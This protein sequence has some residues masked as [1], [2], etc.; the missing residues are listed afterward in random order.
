MQHPRAATIQR[1]PCAQRRHL[2]VSVPKSTA[3]ERRMM[4]ESHEARAAG[5]AVLRAALSTSLFTAR[6]CLACLFMLPSH[7][8][9]FGLR[10]SDPQR[11]RERFHSGTTPATRN[12]CCRSRP[13]LAR[14]YIYN[15]RSV[16]LCYVTRHV[17][18]RPTHYVWACT[19]EL[20]PCELRR[21]LTR[22]AA[23]AP[24]ANRVAARRRRRVRARWSLAMQQRL[25]KYEMG[26]AKER[27]SHKISMH[28]D[29]RDPCRDRTSTTS[30]IY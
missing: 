9:V 22:L 8:Q 5:T 1:R 18:R 13:S 17:C 20:T 27:E 16:R 3:S 29:R 7:Q 12:P 10:G 24:K 6:K 11:I 21:P 19:H 30:P 2:L 23:A 28:R 25:R 14:Y 4:P 15:S 26:K